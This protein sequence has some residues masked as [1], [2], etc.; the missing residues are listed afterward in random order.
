MHNHMSLVWREGVIPI[1][2]YRRASAV[3][4]EPHAPSRPSRIG[5]VL[6]LIGQNLHHEEHEVHEE[7]SREKVS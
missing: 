5:T 1:R 7:T 3:M 6:A 2:V 4:I